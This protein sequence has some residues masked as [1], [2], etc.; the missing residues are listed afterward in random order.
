MDLGTIVSS[1]REEAHLLGREDYKLAEYCRRLLKAKPDEALQKELETI[2][3]EG[4]SADMD[5]MELCRLKLLNL[6]E[7]LGRR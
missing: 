7:R 3:A 4:A 5:G 6:A 1:R 2:L